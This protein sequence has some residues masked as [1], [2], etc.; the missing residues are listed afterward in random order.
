[1]TQV[2]TALLSLANAEASI[3]IAGNAGQDS[4]EDITRGFASSTHYPTL[5]NFIN[6]V[7]ALSPIFSRF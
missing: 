7:R 4:Y 1:M 2:I 5:L 3:R 6:Y